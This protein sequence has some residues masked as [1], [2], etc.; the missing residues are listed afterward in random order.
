[1]EEVGFAPERTNRYRYYFSASGDPLV[2]GSPDGGQHT[3]VT[4]DA[5]M[6][7]PS[8]T[9][10]RAAIPPPLMA[11]LGMHGKCPDECHITMLAVGNL[12]TDST[13]DI[14]SVSTDA[15][16]IDGEAVLAG[17]PFH[18]LDDTSD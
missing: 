4:V 10:L 5:R 9:A 2:T 15:R 18:H 8:E 16:T 11:E 14:W 12:D 3:G 1:V 13:M 17:S 7:P 6:T